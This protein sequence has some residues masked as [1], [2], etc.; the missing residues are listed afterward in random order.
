ML[1][2][3][4]IESVRIK[5]GVTDAPEAERLLGGPSVSLLGSSEL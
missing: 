2:V 3:S 1:S 4:R 5:R